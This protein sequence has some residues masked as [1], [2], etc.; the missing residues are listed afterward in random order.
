MGCPHVSQKQ[1][2]CVCVCLFVCVCVCVCVA[3][4]PILSNFIIRLMLS[5][6]VGLAGR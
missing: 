4:L 3:L 2:V 5:H 6:K 1:S